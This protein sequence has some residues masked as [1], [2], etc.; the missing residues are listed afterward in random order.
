[1]E[2]LGILETRGLVPLI[3]ASAAMGNPA[4]VNLGGAQPPGGG[5]CT[6]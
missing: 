6:A 3:A 2:A 4:R 1:M 5:L